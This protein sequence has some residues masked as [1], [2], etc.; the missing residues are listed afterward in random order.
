MIP[1]FAVKSQLAPVGSYKKEFGANAGV[2]KL[3]LRT[4]WAFDCDSAHSQIAMSPALPP[5]RLI[6]FHLRRLELESMRSLGARLPKRFLEFGLVRF[7]VTA[8]RRFAATPFAGHVDAFVSVRGL[9]ENLRDPKRG[10]Y[11]N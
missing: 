10:G 9:S 1:E 7:D 4:V 2:S 5:N 11:R 6:S 8:S 3:P